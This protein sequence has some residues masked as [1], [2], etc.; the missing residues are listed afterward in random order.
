MKQQHAEPLL[1]RIRRAVAWSGADGL[2]RAISNLAIT[3]VLARLITPGEFGVM[4][5][6]L[7]F[8]AVASVLANFGLSSALIQKQ[9]ATLEDESTALF[10][11]LAMA[12]LAALVLSLCAPWIAE[13]Y[14]QPLLEDVV[15]VLSLGLVF[16]S[17]GSVQSALLRKALDFRPLMWIGMASML[18]SG[19]LAIGLAWAG[20]GVWA[21]VWQSVASSALGTL[22]LWSASRWRPV[23]VLRMHSLRSLLSFGGYMAATSMINAVYVHLY[24]MAIG[25]SYGAADA[26]FYARAH[27]TQQFPAAFLS[28]VLNRV[29]FPAFSEV[30]GNPERLRRGL[31]NAMRTVMLVNVPVCLGMALVAEPLVQLVFGDAWLPSVPL[32]QVLS[33]AGVLWPLQLLNVNALMAQGH[34]RRML[35]I[36]IAKKSLGASV[37]ALTIHWGLLAVAVGQLAATCASFVINAH[38]TRRLLGF[39]A[40]AQLAQLWRIGAAAAA[41]AGVL[42]GLEAFLPSQ[43]GP[44]LG[45]AIALGGGTYGLVAWLLGE[46]SRERIEN[47]T[48]AKLGR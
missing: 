44:R 12:G 4:A 32:L 13:F 2:V 20:Y 45:V 33:L 23:F 48:G 25:R 16:A 11:G 22:L 1:T 15:P 39:G 7:V 24:A 29:A 27:S 3:I 28:N 21:L 31:A 46:L 30:S 38:Y 43:P 18:G 40:T 17:M 47:L 36:E 35:K 14:R 5:M 34:A 6:V 10:F 37:L 8:T 41:M 42:I 19:L 26:G 9:D